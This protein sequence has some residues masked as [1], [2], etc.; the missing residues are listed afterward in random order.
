LLDLG[1]FRA[2]STV[3]PTWTSNAINLAGLLQDPPR[4]VSALVQ[5][6]TIANT[7]FEIANRITKLVHFSVDAILALRSIRATAI[8]RAIHIAFEILG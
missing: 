5:V 4:F 7:R 1:P 8:K 3:V 2:K 6:A